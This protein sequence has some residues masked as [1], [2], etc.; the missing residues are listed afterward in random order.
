MTYVLPLPNKTECL[1]NSKQMTIFYFHPR[2]FCVKKTILKS[3]NEAV[4]LI[5]NPT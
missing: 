2:I 5:Y 1:S 4:N 3:K